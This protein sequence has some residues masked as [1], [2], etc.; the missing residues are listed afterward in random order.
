MHKS[1]FPVKSIKAFF[2]KKYTSFKMK[3]FF[4]PSNTVELKLAIQANKRD[5][6]MRE[7]AYKREGTCA[8]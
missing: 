5:S 1:I 3:G 4:E 7:N 2:G 6:L 8:F